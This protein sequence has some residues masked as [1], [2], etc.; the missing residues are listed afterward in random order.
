MLVENTVPRQ[1]TDRNSQIPQKTN[2]HRPHKHHTKN[3]TQN[4]TPSSRHRAAQKR[5]LSRLVGAARNVITQGWSQIRPIGGNERC[6]G[7][8]QP[9][10]AEREFRS[11]TAKLRKNF[12]PMSPMFWKSRVEARPRGWS[13]SGRAFSLPKLTKGRPSASQDCAHAPEG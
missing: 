10:G 3:P 2:N 12:G 6:Q 1:K 7:E 13:A 9:P 8:P 4:N 5:A 11:E